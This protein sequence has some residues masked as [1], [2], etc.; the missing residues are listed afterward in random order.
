MREI[1]WERIWIVITKS[2]TTKM[3]TRSVKSTSF[4][5][6][7]LN[8]LWKCLLGSRILRMISKPWEKSTQNSRRWWRSEYHYQ[9]N[10][11]PKSQSYKKLRISPTSLLKNSLGHSWLIKSLWKSIRQEKDKH[12]SQS[13]NKWWWWSWA[14]WRRWR[15]CT[16]SKKVLKV[17]QIWEE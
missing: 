17:H 2:M 5:F 8:L 4:P 6:K 15:P 16:Y 7:I 12:G 1:I 9:S 11:M 13:F 14:K 3:Y 10:G